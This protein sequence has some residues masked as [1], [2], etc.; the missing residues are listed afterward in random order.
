MVSIQVTGQQAYTVRPAR[1]ADIAAVM[2]IEAQSFAE[3][4]AEEEAVFAERLAGAEG[5]NYVLERADHS[6]CGYFM[7]EIW[8][9]RQFAPSFFALGHSVR[10][11]HDPAGTTL[12]ISSFALLPEV[13]GIRSADQNAG[14][15]A[16]FFAAAQDCITAL[17]PQLERIILLVHED[18]HKAIT[19]YEAQGFTRIQVLERFPW[20]GTKRAFI[21][22]KI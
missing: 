2:R 20:F 21:Y 18:W 12:Y 16:C 7:A 17:F 13:R 19:I 14:I 8:A 1:S 4:I 6:V 9:A 11:R 22:E 5:C 10:E 15:A 3:G